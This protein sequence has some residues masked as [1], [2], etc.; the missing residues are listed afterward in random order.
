MFMESVNII[1]YIFGIPYITRD[2]SVLVNILRNNSWCDKNVRFWI[3]FLCG[4]I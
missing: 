4:F 1:L 3:F 2:K